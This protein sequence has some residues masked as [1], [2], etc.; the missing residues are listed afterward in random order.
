MVPITIIV[1]DL[2]PTNLAVFFDKRIGDILE[3]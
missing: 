3:K 1:S 2:F